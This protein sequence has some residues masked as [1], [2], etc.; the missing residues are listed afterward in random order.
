MEQGTPPNAEYRE[1]SSHFE[2]IKKQSEEAL[3][4]NGY[5]AIVSARAALRR[6]LGFAEE[7]LQIIAGLLEQAGVPHHF[8]RPD[9]N[10]VEVIVHA[11]DGTDVIY[12][13]NRDPIVRLSHNDGSTSPIYDQ[14]SQ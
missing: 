8:S 12:L 5:G 1:R 10:K 6:A 3:E 7:Q 11:D 2:A 4:D 14:D 13:V 9:A